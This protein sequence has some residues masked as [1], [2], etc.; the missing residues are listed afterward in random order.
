ME[1]FGVVREQGR[2][3]PSLDEY[4]VPALGP[5]DLARVR[6]HVPQRHILPWSYAC[7]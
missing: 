5:L 1:K 4:K 6:A 3:G 7:M 2:P